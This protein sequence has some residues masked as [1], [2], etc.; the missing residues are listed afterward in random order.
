[1][2]DKIK[3]LVALFIIFFSSC[4]ENQNSTNFQV[5]KLTDQKAE[6]KEV[7]QTSSYT[8]LRVEK[9]K[10]DQWIAI[11]KQEITIG[12]IIYYENGLKMNNFTSPELQRTFETV[13]FVQQISDSPIKHDMPQ[14]IQGTIPQKPVLT[15]LEIKIEQPEGGTTIGDLYAKRNNFDGKSIKVRGKVTKVNL[16]IMNRNWI[17]IQDGTSDGEN[18]DLTITTDHEPKVG[19]EVTYSG[20]LGLNKDFGMGYSYSILLENAIPVELY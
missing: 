4:Q 15:K 16:G 17:H 6:V 2:S 3:L 13:Y 18:F 5:P 11:N 20:I 10:Q 1:M 19:D 12:A 9:N 8:Y 14:Q 7:I